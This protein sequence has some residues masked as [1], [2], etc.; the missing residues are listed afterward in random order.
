MFFRSASGKADFA[1]FNETNGQKV[2]PAKESWP[3]RCETAAAISNQEFHRAK[4]NR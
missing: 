2:G 3:G 4:S 1:R